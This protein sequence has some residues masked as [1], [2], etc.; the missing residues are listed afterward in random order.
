VERPNSH[1]ETRIGGQSIFPAYKG[2]VWID[3]KSVRV[4]RIEMQARNI[5]EEFPL[6]SVEWVVDYSFVRI[7]TGQFL[8]PV[9]AENLSCWRGTSQCARNA[10]DFRNYRKFTSESQI[11][12]TDST[13]SF[14][15]EEKPPAKPA[16]DKKK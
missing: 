12:A 11:M 2:T 9:H 14:E 10:I 1:W 16:P 6:D 7:G 8:L 5:P 3:K 13:V 15:G 4:L